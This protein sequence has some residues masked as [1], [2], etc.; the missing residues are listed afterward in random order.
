MDTKPIQITEVAMEVALPQNT[1]DEI[2]RKFGP[3]KARE[4]AMSVSVGG[5]GP[6]LRE[7]LYAQS[8]L[9]LDVIG[10]TLLYETVWVQIWQEWGQLNLEK[11]PVGKELRQVFFQTDLGFNLTFFDGK[12]AHVDVWELPY[13]KAKVYFL[14][15]PLISDVVYPGAKDMPRSVSN[16]HAAS[17]EHRLK[18]SWLIGRGALILAKKLE[19]QA[20][21]SVLS[22]TPTLLSHHRLVKDELQTDPFFADTK[23]VFNDHTPLEYAHPIWDQHTLDMVKIDPAFYLSTP[24]WN[25]QRKTLDI[26]SLLVSHCEG[27]FGVAKKHGDV[28]KAMPSLHAYAAKIK[29]ITNGVRTRD[30]QAPEFAALENPTDEQL[31]Q[32]KQ[33]RKT[34]LIEWAWRRFRLWP[35]W[36]KEAV[37]KKIVIWTRRITPYKRLDILVKMLSVRE[38]RER[39]LKLDIVI[40]I[41]G[42]IHQQDNHAQ[43][44]VYELLDFLSKDKEL[45]QRII[46]VDN[47]NTWEA[48]YFM[49]GADAAIMLADDTREASA[50][51]F[52]KALMNGA[53]ILATADGAVPEFVHFLSSSMQKQ[54]VQYLNMPPDLRNPNI[55]PSLRPDD[56]NGINGFNI[57]YFSGEPTSQGLLEA[58]EAFDFIYQNPAYAASFMRAALIQTAHVSVNRTGQEMK[59]FYE[60]LLAETSPLLKP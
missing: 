30:W 53:A 49:Q 36:A 52:M 12:T 10:I 8:E 42:R 9:G 58:F 17:H 18:Q 31:S 37:N 29:Y 15:C 32:A 21:L 26:T 57:P 38:W 56:L 50:T 23:Y 11:R 40:F 43:D 45:G 39:F 16:P 2:A 54:I 13:G 27:V 24:A 41:G 1:V 60:Q 44:I 19:R 3:D 47:F 46:Y 5:I 20:R 59:V 25:P 6:L 35:N 48:N 4:C 7:R 28:M 14:S 22:E 55:D 33:K 34:I 51:G